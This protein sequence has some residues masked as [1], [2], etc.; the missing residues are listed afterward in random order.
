MTDA[1]AERTFN[2]LLAED[3]PGD[4]RL[5]EETAK[6]S[7][8]S[9]TV[10]VVGDGEEAMSF[11]R[12]EGDHSGAPR[13]DLLLL[14]LAMPK[15]NGFQVLDELNGDAELKGIPVI[16]LTARQLDREQ[17]FARGIHPSQY[18]NKPLDLSRLDEVI[19]LLQSGGG[20]IRESRP[21]ES[22]ATVENRPEDSPRIYPT[23]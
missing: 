18:S 11:L 7:A 23:G 13:P 10:W 1:N 15:K 2:I 19:R 20:L 6:D 22:W 17:L 9:P 12:K 8:F 4:A 14:D 5:T 3:N 21:E 16:V